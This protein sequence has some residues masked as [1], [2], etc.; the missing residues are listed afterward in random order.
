[1]TVGLEEQ[2]WHSLMEVDAEGWQPVSSSWAV[3]EGII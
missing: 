1:M 3:V 2:T